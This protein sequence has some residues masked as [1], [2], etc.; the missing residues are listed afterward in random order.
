MKRYETI[1]GTRMTY[2][3]NKTSNGLPLNWTSQTLAFSILQGNVVCK[4]EVI[5]P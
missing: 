5:H 1:K 4:V 2:S 3:T